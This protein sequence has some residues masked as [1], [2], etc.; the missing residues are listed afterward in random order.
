MSKIL[1]NPSIEELIKLAKSAKKETIADRKNQFKRM[2]KIK[3][4]Y[5]INNIEK[6]YVSNI[7]DEVRIY[8]VQ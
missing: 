2:P 6:L 8:G 5:G 4:G 3:V 1:H 7:I